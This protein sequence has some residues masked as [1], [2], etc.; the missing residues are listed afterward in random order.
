MQVPD[1]Y[2]RDVVAAAH[3]YAIDP[4]HLAGLLS[5]ESGFN[6]R[7]V[8][9]AGA[10]GIAQFMPA[11]AAGMGVNPHNERSSIFGAARYLHE[12]GYSKD[13][14]AALAKYNAGPAPGYF[15]R[16]GPYPDKVLAAARQFGAMPSTSDASRPARA[17]GGGGGGLLEGA[18]QVGLQ[19]TFIGA[20]MFLVVVGARRLMRPLQQGAAA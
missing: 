13:P 6:P 18:A 5:V 10:L 17:D 9:S 19:A 2:R 20:G 3:A 16:A 1:K 14:R 8:S 4:A 12:L 7:A 11:T 15:Q